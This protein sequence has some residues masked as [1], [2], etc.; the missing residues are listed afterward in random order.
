[1]REQVGRL[2]RWYSSPLKNC[3]Q[4]VF[5]SLCIRKRALLTAHRTLTHRLFMCI[6]YVAASGRSSVPYAPCTRYRLDTEVVVV[7]RTRGEH[8]CSCT[9]SRHLG[10]SGG[11]KSCLLDYQS[12]SLLT[13]LWLSCVRMDTEAGSCSVGDATLTHAMR[14]RLFS[15]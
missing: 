10:F 9:A 6:E 8:R 2:S 14:F 15:R 4:C 7:C 3:F 1:M 5:W 13:M 11:A 12:A